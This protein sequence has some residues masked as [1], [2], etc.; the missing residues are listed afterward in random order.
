VTSGDYARAEEGRVKR[1][2]GDADFARSEAAKTRAE[3]YAETQ[4]QRGATGGGNNTP[5]T[6]PSG[7][8]RGG[9]GGKNPLILKEIERRKKEGNVGGKPNPVKEVESKPTDTFDPNSIKAPTGLSDPSLPKTSPKPKSQ[10]TQAQRDDAIRAEM[11]LGTV[12]EA[13]DKITAD[14]A[15]RPSPVV[16]PKGIKNDRGDG[17]S[18]DDRSYEAN[19]AMRNRSPEQKKWDVDNFN[20]GH[21]DKAKADSIKKYGDK[22]RWKDSQGGAD[23]E[24]LGEKTARPGSQD[25]TSNQTPSPLVQPKAGAMANNSPMNK[26]KEPTTP[27]SVTGI[28]QNK[29]PDSVASNSPVTDPN[30][31]KK[32]Y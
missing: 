30:K 15:S 20:R 9:R 26:P 11:G 13:E 6:P 10:M 18:R 28:P 23:L 2:Q 27:I 21:L 5:Y 1:R 24:A 22:L 3:V 14:S 12:A 17:F 29:K 4:A 19:E 16:Q 8:G 31:K 25:T 32:I 7:G